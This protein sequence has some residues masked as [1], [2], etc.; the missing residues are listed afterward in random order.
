MQRCHCLGCS[1]HNLFSVIFRVPLNFS[2]IP[3]HIGWKG[4]VVSCL[5]LKRRATSFMQSDTNY[6]PRSFRISSGIP[7]RLKI[8]TKASATVSVSIFF[9][10]TASG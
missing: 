8:S 7:R 1:L 10:G 2:V 6:V 5:I 3:L 9:N 4:V